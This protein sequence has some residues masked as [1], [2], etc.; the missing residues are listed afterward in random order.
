LNFV[1]HPWLSIICAAL[2]CGGKGLDR[3]RDVRASAVES[4]VEVSWRP[5]AGAKSYRVQLVDLDARGPLSAP[6]TVRAPH[7]TLPGAYAKNAGVWVDAVPGG[8]SV[9][10]VSA[11]ARGGAGEA[12]QIFGPADF[13]GGELRA[14]FPS[15]A[16]GERLGVLLVNS[17]GRDEA[18]ARVDVS[19]VAQEPASSAPPRSAALRIAGA[20]AVSLH[21]AARE[22]QEA[23]APFSFATGSVAAAE[24]S[25]SLAKRSFCVV[26]G[27]DFGRH[28]RK[29]A[30]RVADTAHA[31]FFVDDQD[32]SHY[33]GNL[34]DALA[35]AFEEKVWPADAAAFGAPTDVDANGKVLVLLT[36]ELGA[37][38][39]GGWLIGYFGNG[40]L[41]RAR[42][43]S[44]DCSGS[45]SNHAEIVYL[46]DL[47]NGAANGYSAQDLAGTVYPATLAH[48]LQ[49]LLNLGHRCVE[50][51]CDGPEDTWINE[52]LSKVA[53]DLAGYGWNG[54][55]GRAEG[56]A[57]LSRSEGALR[58]YDGRSLTRWEGDPIGNY[59]GAHSFLRFFT[60]RFGS[61]MAG[62]LAS[63]AGG[64]DGL[65]DALGR[66]LPRAMAEWA[67]AL[68]L[69][70]E[71][72]APYSYSGGAWSPLHQRL[73]HLEY[74]APG[75]GV[76]LRTDGIA[77]FV[78][79][80][81][82]GG[83]A[84]VVVR[85]GERVSP[86]VVVVRIAG[87]LPSR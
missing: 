19:G 54:G 79:G 24:P 71:A 47:Q 76:S 51:P 66:P 56:A 75:A 28:V 33:E 9:G 45:G 70:N 40:D 42:D 46:N 58:G 26:P 78:S 7:A 41:L 27:L 65:E 80:A 63:G 81:G 74:R 86:H 8:R 14:D 82:R 31:E 77:A 52:A 20:P 68:L 32:L 72:G 36:H 16:A 10:F 43:N 48:E 21:E 64:L 60:D 37:H 67:T 6:V 11:G 3:P 30:T 69:S 85:S 12:W 15:L 17:G 35:R 25:G 83:S 53:E 39:N 59:Q 62:A 18:Q 29:P 49:H 87:D 23:A 57:Y 1:R 73:R 44:S 84:Q 13:R 61:E 22:A 34:I 4:G 2:A 5:V 50:K 55:M 38:L